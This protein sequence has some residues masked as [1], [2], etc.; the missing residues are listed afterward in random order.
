M[1]I[2][3]GTGVQTLRDIL[4]FVITTKLLKIIIITSKIFQYIN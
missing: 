2:V 4:V 3:I 1:R